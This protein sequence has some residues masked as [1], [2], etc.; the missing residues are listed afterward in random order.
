MQAVKMMKF[1]C[2]LVNCVLESGVSCAQAV[3]AVAHNE[4]GGCKCRVAIG[5]GDQSAKRTSGTPPLR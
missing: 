5:S 2:G 4:V 1:C 3:S